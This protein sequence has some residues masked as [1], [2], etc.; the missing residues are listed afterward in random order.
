[1][2][3]QQ[4]AVLADLLGLTEPEHIAAYGAIFDKGETSVPAALIE[5]LHLADL[6]IRGAYVI[7][8]PREFRIT[9]GHRDTHRAPGALKIKVGD[10]VRLVALSTERWVPV[11]VTAS[12]TT[13][14]G[15]YSG[16]VVEQLVKASRYQVG[17]GVKFSE[18]QVMTEEPTAAVGRHR[19]RY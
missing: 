18:D 7:H 4:F 1:M 3:E 16:V 2:T 9:V 17:D 8:G 15:Y 6:A 10:M 13:P 14:A 19:K 5:K 11:R 12:P